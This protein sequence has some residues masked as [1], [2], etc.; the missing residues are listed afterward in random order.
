MGDAQPL[1]RVVRGEPDALELAA[2]IAGLTAAA[3]VAE[4]TDEQATRHRW[5]D[6]SHALR[7]GERGL[8]ARGANAWRWSLHP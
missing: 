4:D 2:L 7:G 3:A 6:R 1:V 8:P 5:A